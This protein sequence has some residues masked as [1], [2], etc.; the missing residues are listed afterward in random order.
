MEP[1][2]V[3]TLGPTY[4]V[5]IIEVSLFTKQQQ[6]VLI[7]QSCIIRQS[8]TSQTHTLKLAMAMQY[9]YFLS[10]RTCNKAATRLTTGAEVKE[11]AAMD[12]KYVL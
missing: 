9:R 6:C 3:D 12:W 5:L 7:L 10:S 2:N 8:E 11:V 1:L 4:S